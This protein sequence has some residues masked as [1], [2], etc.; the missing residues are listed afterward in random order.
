[1]CSGRWVLAA[2]GGPGGRGQRTGRTMRSRRRCITSRRPVVRA[3]RHRCALPPC[4]GPCTSPARV[5]IPRRRRCTTVRGMVHAPWSTG[6]WVQAGLWLMAIGPPPSTPTRPGQWD[7][8]HGAYGAGQFRH[9]A[10]YGPLS[11]FCA[12]TAL[13]FRPARFEC[14]T[15]RCS[16]YIALE[17]VRV[18]P[19]HGQALGAAHA[20]VRLSLPASSRVTVSIRLVAHHGAA[21]DLPEH[22]GVQLGHQLLQRGADQVFGTG[23]EHAQVLVGRLEVPAPRPPAPCGC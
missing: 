3:R 8:G 21:M 6:R 14:P 9:G 10:G 15:G 5:V 19:A 17:Q 20:G 13:A 1:M 16:L 22:L 11:G 7:Y 12:T 4:T 23:R 18:E 2:P